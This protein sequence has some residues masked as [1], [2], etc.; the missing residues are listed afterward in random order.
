MTEDWTASMTWLRSDST[1]PAYRS[2]RS[3]GT[4]AMRATS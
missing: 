3:I 2:I 1:G 4:P